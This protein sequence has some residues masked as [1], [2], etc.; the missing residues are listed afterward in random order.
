[1]SRENI[2]AI[3][4]YYDRSY[5]DY[6]IL[7]RITKHWGMHFAY[8]DASHRRMDEAILNTNR[9]LAEFADIKP[10]ER[11]L[12]VGCGVGGSA[13]WL[14]KNRNAEVTGITIVESQCQKA[15]EVARKKGVSD[16]TVFYVRDMRD[17]GFPSNSFDVVWAIESVCHAEVKA[18]FL[19]EAYRV[20]RPGGRFVMADGFQRE[21]PLTG[22]E[23]KM[24][25]KWFDGWAVPNLATIRGFVW[26]MERLGFRRI[27]HK[28]ATENVM[29]FSRF[30]YRWGLVGY[31]VS[32]FLEMLRLRTKI[33][34]GNVI[35]AIWQYRTLRR[36]FWTY[37]L[38]YAEK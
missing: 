12:D 1:M 7:L 14:A 30:L 32:K 37:Q 20:L 3:A 15:R 25:E 27:Q 10:G 24:M 36:G 17:T 23:K 13:V 26:D 16:K 5:R 28:N 8:Y 2:Q 35:A 9:I 34:T 11:V 21:A 31:P 22:N 6:R 4:E 38:I 33:E 19:K 18:D 29:P